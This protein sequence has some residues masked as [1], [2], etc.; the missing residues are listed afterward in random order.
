MKSQPITKEIRS[1]IWTW[2]QESK[3][4]QTEIARKLGIAGN[5]AINSWLNGNAK[6]IRPRNWQALYPYLKP[7]LPPDYAVNQPEKESPGRI[8]NIEISG[9]LSEFLDMWQKLSKSEQARVLTFTAELL[10]K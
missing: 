8:G 9:M 2:Y 10:E 5:S 3:L 7:Y 4:T 1:A 6:T